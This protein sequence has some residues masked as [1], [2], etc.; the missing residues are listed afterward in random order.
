VEDLEYFKIPIP[1]GE[2]LRILTSAL[3]GSEWPA[4]CSSRFIPEK[5]TYVPLEDISVPS[6]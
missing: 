4:S 5:E 1:E 2:L 6:P 3:D